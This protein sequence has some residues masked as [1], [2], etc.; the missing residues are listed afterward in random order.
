VITKGQTFFGKYR[1]TVFDNEDPKLLGRVQ[2]FV[3]D[4]LGETP[5]TWALPCLPMAGTGTPMG[6]Y[7]IPPVGTGVWIEF[8]HGDPGKPIWSGCWYSD[9]TQP[10][11]AP[12]SPPPISQLVIQTQ[13][14]TTLSISDLPTPPGGILLQTPKGA[15][16]SISDTAGITISNGKGA[17]ITLIGAAVNIN[18]GAL[19]VT[20]P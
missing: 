18:N 17:S 14:G 7:C 19:V 5:S 20:V 16:I 2:A 15:M 9:G 13:Q 6:V 10:V 3:T 11:L 1:G 12:L 8:E 4:V